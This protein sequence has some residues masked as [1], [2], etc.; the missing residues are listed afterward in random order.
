MVVYGYQWLLV[1][2]VDGSCWLCNVCVMSVLCLS[3]VSLDACLVLCLSNVLISV[4]LFVL[5]VSDA[6]LVGWCVLYLFY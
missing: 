5:F 6:L 3:Y 1:V 4:F 2:F